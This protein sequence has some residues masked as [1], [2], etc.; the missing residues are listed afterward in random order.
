MFGIPPGAF[1]FL[2]LH[3]RFGISG[4]LEINIFSSSNYISLLCERALYIC[5]LT[6]SSANVK[7]W[8]CAIYLG[9]VSWM[10]F[11]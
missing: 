1:R 7:D 9:Y 5:I 6:L 3:I 11:C 8:D 2:V 10:P 4:T